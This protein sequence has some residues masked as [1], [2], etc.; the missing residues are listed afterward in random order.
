MSLKASKSACQGTYPQGRDIGWEGGYGRR[1]GRE[2]KNTKS[3]CTMS[4]IL[5]LFI[6]VSCIFIL[7]FCKSGKDITS[8]THDIINDSLMH[9]IK[10]D[11][12]NKKGLYS[13]FS[14]KQIYYECNFS[15]LQILLTEQKIFEKIKMDPFFKKSTLKNQFYKFDR[16]YL[17]LK[18]SSFE[19]LYILYTLL[20]NNKY[21]FRSKKYF[22]RDKNMWNKYLMIM[23]RKDIYQFEVIYSL[24]GDDKISIISYR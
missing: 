15:K 24:T 18:D 6:F 19:S 20:K 21:S 16:Q 10:I 3:R 11:S 22:F 23:Q 12:T 14:N 8:L 13:H 17:I 9:F 7:N 2:E 1:L 4:M 5:R